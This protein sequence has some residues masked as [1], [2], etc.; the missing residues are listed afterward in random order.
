MNAWPTWRQWAERALAG[1]GI[2][3][4]VCVLAL[5]AGC[6]PQPAGKGGGQA[7]RSSGGAAEQ[8][9]TVDL[10]GNPVTDAGNALAAGDFRFKAVRDE[11]GATVV[12]GG[13]KLKAQEV[14]YDYGFT[15]ISAADKGLAAAQR[16]SMLDKVYYYAASYNTTVLNYMKDHPRK[17]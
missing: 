1:G 5:L 2:A 14:G 15:T 4:V 8:G 10:T 6:E 3:L 9:L 16:L 12:P 7:S 11:H 13:S 17:R